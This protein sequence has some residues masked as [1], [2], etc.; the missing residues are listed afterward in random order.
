[1]QVFS[2]SRLP[3]LTS[4][5][6]VNLAEV[7]TNVSKGFADVVLPS[8]A[9]KRASAVAPGQGA[10]VQEGINKARFNTGHASHAHF[11]PCPACTC[12]P[13]RHMHVHVDHCLMHN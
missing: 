4:D 10:V 3:A 5:T 6:A 1:M 12:V 7:V 13:A 9:E 2:P 11:R 8:G